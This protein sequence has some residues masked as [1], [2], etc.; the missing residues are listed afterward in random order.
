MKDQMQKSNNRVRLL[1]IMEERMESRARLRQL[2]RVLL[3]PAQ[4]DGQSR[5]RLREIQDRRVPRAK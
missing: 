3:R 4:T 1:R 2:D 5:L